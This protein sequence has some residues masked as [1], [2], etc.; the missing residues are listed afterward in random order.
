MGQDTL[1]PIGMGTGRVHLSLPSSLLPHKLHVQRFKL[2][3]RL[4]AV[5]VHI[6][7]M[8]GQPRNSRGKE[9]YSFWCSAPYAPTLHIPPSAPPSPQPGRDSFPENHQCFSPDPPFP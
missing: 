2:G 9:E 5:L 3:G 6:G 7:D 1:P 4:P 8:L